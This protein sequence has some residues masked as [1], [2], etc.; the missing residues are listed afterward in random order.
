MPPLLDLLKLCP[1]L[2]R[3]DYQGEAPDVK[4]QLYSAFASPCNTEHTVFL[5]V[6]Y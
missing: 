1:E 2:P 5:A 3:A 6:S 4:D